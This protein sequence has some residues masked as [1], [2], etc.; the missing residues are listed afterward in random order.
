VRR[1]LTPVQRVDRIVRRRRAI[2]LANDLALQVFM[3]AVI[4]AVIALFAALVIS[5]I[6]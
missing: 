3:K 2:D 4:L 1:R 6:V 5:A